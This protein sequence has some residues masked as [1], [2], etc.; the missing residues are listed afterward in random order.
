MNLEQLGKRDRHLQALLQQAQQWHRL[1][2]EVKNILPVNLR[3]HFQTACVE[4]GKLVLIAANNMA[5]S[6]L[7]M[8]LPSLLPQL[9][10]LC[11]DIAEVQVR[12]LPKTPKPERKNTLKLSDAVLQSFEEAATRLQAQ[13]PKLA[14]RL[15]QL[16]KKHHRQE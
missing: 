3:L 14:E 12:V 13:H 4:N 7:K 16:A 6:R 10:L 15:A 11:H 5:S 9:K 1:D 2:R 8:I